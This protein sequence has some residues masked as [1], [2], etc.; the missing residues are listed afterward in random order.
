MPHTPG[1]TDQQLADPTTVNTQRNQNLGPTFP[2]TGSTTAFID[3]ERIYNNGFF[4]QDERK[5][6][7][8]NGVPRNV[9]LAPATKQGELA[10]FRKRLL[11]GD[12]LARGL[13]NSLVATG[14]LSKSHQLDQAV[15][16]YGELLTQALRSQ[17]TSGKYDPTKGRSAAQIMNDDLAYV[18][19][20][21]SQTASGPRTAISIRDYTPAQAADL[22]R[23]AYRRDYGVDPTAKQIEA[24]AKALRKAALASPGKTRYSADGSVS[25]TIEGFDFNSWENGYMAAAIP[26]QAGDLGG[27]LGVTQDLVAELEQDYGVKLTNDLKYQLLQKVRRGDLDKNGVLEVV[28]DAAKTK[29]GA[30]AADIDRGVTVRQ[31]ADPY[32]KAMAEIWEMPESS[33]TVDTPEIATALS[34]TDDKGNVR[35][36]STAEFQE[37]LRKNPKWLNT[38]SAQQQAFGLVNGLLARMGFKA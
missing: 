33:V 22:A 26:T 37:G 30:L 2:G 29:Y 1:H 24:Y 38:V 11:Q 14:R 7:V 10:E 21:K 28:K 25:T 18:S 32:I 36:Q 3:T 6:T 19:A 12:A 20:L 5:F 23:A 35:M 13:A 16:A 8:V 34:M 17:S 15:E 9:V 4:T 27:T 31:K